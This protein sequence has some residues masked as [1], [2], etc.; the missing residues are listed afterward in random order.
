MG[1]WLNDEAINS[2]ID[3]LTR[4]ARPTVG[5]FSTFFFAFLRE[6]FAK[7]ESW[8]NQFRNPVFKHM[9]R[10]VMPIHFRTRKHWAALCIDF[11]RRV[12]TYMDSQFHLPSFTFVR[13]II[14]NYLRSL[15]RKEEYVL[16]MDAWT[17]EGSTATVST[18][19]FLLFVHF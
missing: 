6:S 9:E 13:D 1:Q 7:V 18:N 12:V 10:I 15:A 19:C 17:F 11:K 2:Y 4:F 3:V 14:G 8:H 16:D 5:I